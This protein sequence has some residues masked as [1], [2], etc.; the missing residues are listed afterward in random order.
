MLVSAAKKGWSL[1]WGQTLSRQFSKKQT[2]PK[3]PPKEK[4]FGIAITDEKMI[5]L[6]TKEDS[7]VAE[8]LRVDSHLP[9]SKKWRQ[10]SMNDC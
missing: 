9:D 6:T 1:A 8:Q 7:K 2:Q 4:N 5:K 3:K 10:K